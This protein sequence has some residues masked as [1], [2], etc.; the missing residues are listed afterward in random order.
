[1]IIDFEIVF[2]FVQRLIFVFFSC[3]L[4]GLRVSK[5]ARSLPPI[6]THAGIL[7]DFLENGWMVDD[8]TI[9]VHLVVYV[10]IMPRIGNAY[11]DLS[12]AD[13][14]HKFPLI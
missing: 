4:Q 14:N 2:A 8:S 12:P 6:P 13:Y 10:Y 11:K 9:N 3:F 7:D 5:S 1:M